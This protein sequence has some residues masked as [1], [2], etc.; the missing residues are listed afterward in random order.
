M[1]GTGS[2]AE[3]FGVVAGLAGF[4]AGACVV[5]GLSARSARAG[6]GEASLA[7]AAVGGEAGTSGRSRLVA[8]PAAAVR[9]PAR[10]SGCPGG[11]YRTCVY[12][13]VLRKCAGALIVPWLHAQ[14]SCSL[15]GFGGCLRATCA[16]TS[17][18][19]RGGLFPWIV[20]WV[21]ST[22]A[23]TGTLTRQFNSLQLSLVDKGMS[24]RQC[25]E[26]F[27]VPATQDIVPGVRTPGSIFLKGLWTSTP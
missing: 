9:V 10:V 27:K 23:D 3:S 21:S 8:T 19:T 18:P 7:V 1:T 16:T 24:T 13:A 22:T 12:N 5:A 17:A 25:V 26:N 15:T 4:G 11:R 20:Q 6:G 2:L 14:L